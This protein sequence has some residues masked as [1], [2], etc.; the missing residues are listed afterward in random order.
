MNRRSLIRLTA[1]VA[2]L[3][4]FVRVRLA[5]AIQEFGSDS[6][7]NC[8]AAPASSCRS[9]SVSAVWTQALRR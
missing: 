5:A 8:G 4:P 6:V 3:L 2:V 9:N 1:R 7:A